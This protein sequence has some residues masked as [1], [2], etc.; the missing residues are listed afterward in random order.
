MIRGPCLC[1]LLAVL[2]TLQAVVCHA[3]QIPPPRNR[4]GRTSAS[5][6]TH[7]PEK[8]TV[9]DDKAELSDSSSRFLSAV[10]AFQIIQKEQLSLA[11]ANNASAR[12][13]VYRICCG[14]M[15]NRFLVSFICVNAFCL[16]FSSILQLCLAGI[17]VLVFTGHLVQQVG[18]TMSTEPLPRTH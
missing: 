9:R 4:P 11:A 8:S 18:Q 3:S 7:A 5:N 14:E 16:V 12:I 10:A 15:G 17:C 13:L 6:S 2:L 1:V